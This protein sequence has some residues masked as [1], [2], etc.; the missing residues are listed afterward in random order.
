[1]AATNEP[2]GTIQGGRRKL[3]PLI[4]TMGGQRQSH[5]ESM[6]AHPTMSAHFESPVFSPGVPQRSIR[7][8]RGLL[9]VANSA[10]LLPQHEWEALSTTGEDLYHQNPLTYLDCLTGP[11]RSSKPCD[12]PVVPVLPG[13]EGSQRDKKLHY[14]IEL[15]WKS[16][17]ISRERSVL[18]CFLAHLIAMK[19]LVEEDFDFVLEDNVRVPV[20]EETCEAEQERKVYCECAERI[21]ATLDASTKLSAASSIATTNAEDSNKQC[22]LRYY[23]WLGSKANLEWIFTTHA[24]R[25]RDRADYDDSDGVIFPYPT[26]DEFR[27]DNPV[28]TRRQCK[29][30]GN[31]GEDE[32]GGGAAEEDNKGSG[33]PIWGAYA[34]WISREGYEA[35]LSDLRNDVGGILWR[36]KSMQA[37][38]V[39]PIDKVL[40]R[41]VM[42]RFGRDA[43]HVAALPS[44]VRAPMLRS[45]IHSQWDVEF[46]KSSEYQM[47]VAGQGVGRDTEEEENNGINRRWR[48]LY[49]D[50]LWLTDDEKKVTARRNDTGNWSFV[51]TD[52]R[53]KRR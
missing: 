22:H 17:S 47:Q 42:H 39:K 31:G 28:P 21:W 33:T 41:R 46:C 48:P 6:F 16:K 30:N 20:G 13:R 40:P 51:A 3:R 34:Y 29:D 7:S 26:V 4:I 14:S 36:G 53:E 8:A 9:Q 43:V 24:K 19:R 1:M 44:F 45:T 23:G 27:A 12:D 18:A 37:Y 49:W 38:V 10:G 5:L 35:L 11:G 2:D 50:T 25:M 15:W 32:D 52:N